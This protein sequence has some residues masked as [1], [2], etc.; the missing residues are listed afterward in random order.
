[1]SGLAKVIEPVWLIHC[2][3]C[4]NDAVSYALGWREAI[5][6]FADEGWTRER[7][8]TFCPPCNGVVRP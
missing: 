8:L 7:S 3:R 2:S 4:A 1:M 5:Q 6:Q